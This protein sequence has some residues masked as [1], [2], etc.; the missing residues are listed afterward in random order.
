M[1]FTECFEEN[2]FEQFCINY[3]NEKIQNYCTQ[4]L[5][6]DEQEW[7]KVEGVKVPEIGFPGNDIVLSKS[8]LHH[9]FY[10]ISH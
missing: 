10:S 5:I 8:T 9:Y 1:I 2:Q 4:R 6:V 3:A 7:Y